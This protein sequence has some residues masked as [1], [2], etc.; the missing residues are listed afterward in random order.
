MDDEVKVTPVVDELG[1]GGARLMSV[2][3]FDRFLEGQIIGPGT[4]P[5][6]DFGTISVSAVV[7]WKAFPQIGVE[8]VNMADREREKLFRYLFKVSRQ[9]I[10][11]ER[12][13]KAIVPSPSTR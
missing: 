3:H 2:K 11:Y 8:F 6:E 12:A 4:L 13:K 5:L 9:A 10:R 7:K 1:I